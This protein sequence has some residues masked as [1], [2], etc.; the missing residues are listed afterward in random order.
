MRKT[1]LLLLLSVGVLAG[2]G[3][4]VIFGHTV[5]E[6][7]EASPSEPAPK[8]S[9][10][11]GSSQ[12][13]VEAVRLPPAAQRVKAVTLSLTDDAA[14]K[15]TADP[16]FHADV[17]LAAI[18]RE[19]RARQLLDAQDAAAASTA[20]VVID[21]FDMR[22]T[23]NAV[24]FGYI[25]KEGTLAGDIHVRDA[26][27]NELQSFDVMAETRLSIAQDGTDTNALGALYRRFAVLAADRLAGTP[28]KP[29]A[30]TS[31]DVPR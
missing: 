20:D 1:L 9:S 2:C 16:G 10:S 26:S 12:I 29:E 24:V 18:Q 31:N 22:A 28:T 13:G 23:S 21:D 25:F 7:N 4:V 27:G 8:K 14:A 6:G 3:Q 19:L 15:A 30:Q 5:K 17:L 11:A